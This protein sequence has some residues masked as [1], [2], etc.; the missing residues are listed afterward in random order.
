MHEGFTGL[1]IDRYGYADNG[2]AIAAAVTRAGLHERDVIAQTDR[3]IAFDLRSLAAA[4][5]AVTAKLPTRPVPAT[6]AMSVC[7]S[8]PLMNVE[9]IGSATAPFGGG[10]PSVRGS[11]GF[12][13]SGWAVDQAHMAPAAAV[14]VAIDQTPVPSLYGSE[15]PDVSA[16]FQQADLS[17]QRLHG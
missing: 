8:Q 1:V 6:S 11:R 5:D 16:Y 4:G 12:K 2:A 17:P 13:V 7:G 3:Y 9:Q 15:R 10:P 14:D